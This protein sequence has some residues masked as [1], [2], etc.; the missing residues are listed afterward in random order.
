MKKE[1]SLNKTTNYSEFVSNE[2]QQPM[3]PAHVKNLMA[4]MQEHGYKPSKPVECYY[5]HKLKKF[6]VV[7]GHHRLASAKALGIPFYYVV[8]G[9]ESQEFIGPGNWVVKKWKVCSF[10][11]MYAAKGS[12]DYRVLLEYV[13][14]GIPINMAASM[15][16]G[17]ASHSGNS[18]KLVQ[19]GNFRIKTTA[20]ANIIAEMIQKL[21]PVASE[22]TRR[23]YIEAISVLLFVDAFDYHTF[24]HKVEI[25][26]TMLQKC[27]NRDQALEIIEEIYNYRNQNKV[28][29]RFLAK[30]KMRER[31]IASLM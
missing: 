17:Q 11:K 4:S 7:D 19:S 6:I 15:L 1:A 18:T 23:Y 14:L 12:H 29:L 26:P 13:D 28:N 5:D 30:Q 31:K 24:T 9:K 21:K 25:N 20:Y 27:A 3:S 22:I 2:F 10:A 8:E 16:I